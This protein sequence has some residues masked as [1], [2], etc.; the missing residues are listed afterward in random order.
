MRRVLAFPSSA[1]RGAGTARQRQVCGLLWVVILRWPPTGPARSGRP[2]DRLRGPR[3][4][5]CLGR[6]PSRLG[7]P[8]PSVRRLG[9]V[10]R[11]APQGDGPI[12]HKA[13]SRRDSR[14]SFADFA[15]R[16]KRQRNPGSAFKLASRSRI[17]RSLSSGRP[18]RAGSVGSHPGHQRE[19]RRNAGRRESPTSAPTT[20]ILS[21]LRGRTEERARRASGGTRSPV[22]VPPRLLLR[23]P[24]A[25]AQLRLRASWDAAATGVTRLAPVP[26]QRAPRRPVIVPAGRIP[27]AARE[28]SANPSAGTAPAPSSGLPPE[29]VPSERDSC[30][31][32]EMVTSVNGG[33]Y[34]HYYGDNSA[35]A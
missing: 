32:S 9:L 2:D 23:R 28:R 8:R 21:R 26:V 5:C 15:A 10:W 11:R 14:P 31:V 27:E 1:K 7:A 6:R 12:Q 4:I 3:R 34:R 16:M 17:S 25:T 19:G 13:L 29:G 24:N 33:A 18:L 30:N 20:F 22:G 35:A